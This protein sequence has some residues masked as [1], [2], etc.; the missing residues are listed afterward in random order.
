MTNTDL[1]DTGSVLAAL[2]DAGAAGLKIAALEDALGLSDDQDGEAQRA[3][4]RRLLTKMAKDGA[5]TRPARGVYAAPA[6]AATQGAKK[7]TKK[8]AAKKAA[9]KKAATKKAATKKAATKKAATKK[10]ATKKA[11][12][13]KAAT[14]K[15]ATKKAATKKA[16]TKK[17]ATKKAATKKAATKKAATKKAATK[18]AATKKAATKKA[19]TKKKDAAAKQSATKTAASDEPSTKKA[20]AKKAPKKKAPAKSPKSKRGA[21]KAAAPAHEEPASEAPE[22]V[23]DAASGEGTDEFYEPPERERLHPSQI[24]GAEI[25]RTRR[26]ET[27]PEEDLS[28]TGRI[29]V[30]PAGYGF[31]ELEDGTGTVFVPARHRGAALDGDRVVLNTWSGYKGT[32]GRVIE[33]LS[34]GR[35]KLTGTL[36]RTGRAVYLEPDDPRIAT[37]YGHVPLIDGPPQ[38]KVG[39]AAVVEIC[40]YPTHERPELVGRLVRVLG[41]PDDPRTEIEKILAFADLP[42]EFPRD[43]ARRGD[44]TST[45]VRTRDQVDRVDLRDR[46]FVTIDPVTARDFDDA[47]C[48]EDGPHGGP[49]VWVA[50]ADV[51]HYV[52][53]DDPI[54]REAA[55]RGVSVYLPDRVVPMLPL[56]LSAGICSLNP[57]VDRCA[58]VVRLDLTDDGRVLERDFAAAVI[59][60]HA[61]LDYPGVAAALSGDFRGRRDH[62]RPWAPAL[63]RLAA[64]AQRM[65]TRRRAR[66][67]LELTLAEP[68]VILDADEA[69]LVRDIVRSKG[70]EDVRQAYE[71]VEEFMIAANE[72]VGK[73]FAERNLPTVWR[74]HAP[75]EPDRLHE[76]LPVLANFG[77][78]LTVEDIEAATKPTGMRRIIE[79]IE[80]QPAA[81][82]LSFQVLRSLKQ[83]QYST[84]PI[85]HFGLASPFYLHFTS[86]IRRYADLL[87]HRQ[88]KHYL[89]A[90]GKPSGGGARIPAADIDTLAER[91]AQISTHERRAV[92]VEREAVSM[93][94]AYFMRGQVGE[95]FTG[96]VSAVTNFGAFVELDAPF[97]EGLIKLDDLGADAFG[98]DASSMRLRG[99][100]SGLRLGLGDP[101]TIEVTNVSV[102]RRRI[103]F[104]LISVAGRSSPS[105]GESSGEDEGTPYWKSRRS[106][107]KRPGGRDKDRG[108]GKNKGKSRSGKRRSRRQ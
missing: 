51:S 57:E 66:G 60:S 56:P 53:I 40:R 6:K 94:R 67:A 89:H 87:V 41:K 2:E 36:Q 106:R 78:K 37:D 107:N 26:G 14:K 59:R 104:K 42:T 20:A 31:V 71:L 38:S 55:V 91:C 29:T 61:R 21:A 23:E 7:A 22:A 32:E 47:V 15:A 46:P 81:A 11:A 96:R 24:P 99:R 30:H 80:G 90:D 12:T 62:Y 19:A 13:K 18:K 108:K 17:A 49:R 34:R 50:V 65:R 39:Q 33:V 74:I 10:A 73:Y 25:T 83:A 79:A 97:V 1:F 64:L 92:E 100:R 102:A 5:L 48:I 82:S 44:E 54:D 101:V 75:P 98:F 9:A 28:R 52:E 70:A 69:E 27:R 58:M 8:A 63:S 93:Y 68:Y 88:L 45:T 86:P 3:R 72:A 105:G 77:I 4:L 95:Q 85:G 35:A 84:D 76:L 16:A 103:D 43:V